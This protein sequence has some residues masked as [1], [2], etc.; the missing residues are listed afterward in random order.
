M[1]KR[2]S[3]TAAAIFAT[4]ALT[5]IQSTAATAQ[6]EKGCQYY[7][8]TTCAGDKWQGLG[9]SS[10]AQC[11]QVERAV[12]E[13]GGPIDAAQFKAERTLSFPTTLLAN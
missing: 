1:N 13:N 2:S 10:R 7:A 3:R 5:S 9:Y 6:Y 8:V 4:V 11:Y 12:C